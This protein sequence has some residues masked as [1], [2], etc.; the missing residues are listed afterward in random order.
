MNVGKVDQLVKDLPSLTAS[1][2]AVHP[3]VDDVKD[4]D[5]EETVGLLEFVVQLLMVGHMFDLG[6]DALSHLSLLPH[7]FHHHPERVVDLVLDLLPGGRE[8]KEVLF[9]GEGGS[10]FV[11]SPF[12][13]GGA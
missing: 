13:F 12:P 1:E 8:E 5:K 9:S 10:G 4:P 6:F 3:V 2:K 11:A 7:H